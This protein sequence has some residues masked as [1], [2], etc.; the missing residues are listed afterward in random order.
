MRELK[1]RTPYTIF[2]SYTTILFLRKN[3]EKWVKWKL[4]LNIRNKQAAK[5][6]SKGKRLGLSA[7]RSPKL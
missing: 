7:S 1:V 6:I 4:K 2:F 5:S 3:M